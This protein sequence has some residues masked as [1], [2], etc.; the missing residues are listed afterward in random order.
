MDPTAE[1]SCTRYPPPFDGEHLS[2]LNTIRCRR[3]R[4]LLK[5]NRQKIVRVGED[6]YRV[7]SQY[8]GGLYNVCLRA[9]CEHCSCPDY[10]RYG[11]A[12]AAQPGAFHCKHL[13]AALLMKVKT[14]V[15]RTALH[16]ELRAE[17]A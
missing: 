14:D 7:P 17:A 3:G 8:G 9:G 5:T 2:A 10:A 13:Y 4:A 6:D 15:A 16:T 12:N 11:H 1:S